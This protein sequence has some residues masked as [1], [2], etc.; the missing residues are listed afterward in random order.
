MQLPNRLFPF[1]CYFLKSN[2]FY[3]SLIFFTGVVWATELSVT[4]YLFKLL[5][6][7]ANQQGDTPERLLAVILIPAILYVSMSVILN[8]SFRLYDYI[9]IKMFIRLYTDITLTVFDYTAG[10]SYRFFQENFAGSIANKILYL[11][12]DI[13]SL[14]RAVTDN[15]VPKILAVL[16]AASMLMLVQP[17]F[18]I[19]LLIWVFLFVSGTCLLAVKSTKN[20]LVFSKSINALDGKLIDS[21]SN[22]ITGKIFANLDFESQRMADIH[23][24]VNNKY[25]IMQMFNMK[26]HALQGV[27]VTILVAV[28]L[29]ALIYGR[30]H[31]WVTVGD[32]VFVL[33]LSASIIMNVWNL[34]QELINFTRDSGKCQDALSLINVPHEIKEISHA[35]DLSV[36]QG[37]I[38]FNNVNFSYQTDKPVFRQLCVSIPAGQKVGLVGYSGGGKSTFVKLILRLFDIQSGEISVDQQNIQE[39]SINSLRKN[40]AYIPQEP[41][42][43]HRTIIENIR[44]GRLDASDDD[45]IAASKKAHCHEFIKELSEGYDALVG[46]RGVKLSGGQRQRIA[47]ARA[48]LKQSPILI[49]DEA[50]SALDSVTE[51]YIQDSLHEMMGNKTTIVIAH[52]LCTLLEMDRILLFKEGNIVE[53]G[54]LQELKQQGGYF[55]QLWEMQ[56]GGYLPEL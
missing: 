10:H 51:K 5:V 38:Q 2:K 24:D 52:R 6:D 56:G 34:G 12:R 31:E 43:F 35:S 23:V 39:V 27:G 9:C 49:L 8:L 32:F 41:E 48:I 15:F 46:E 25:K 18:S 53:D 14:L 20:A 1:V 29:A 33:S 44:Y 16:I 42:L 17:L 7:G 4:P 45:V 13:E 3:L 54:S 30:M 28:M 55:S 50:T 40:I 47:I 26:L 11:P 19:I 37:E 36:T 21:V 22:I